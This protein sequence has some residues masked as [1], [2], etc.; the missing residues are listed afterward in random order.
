MRE[1]ARFDQRI[2]SRDAIRGIDA[3][4]FDGDSTDG[5]EPVKDRSCPKEVVLPTIAS[6]V[7]ERR[8]LTG[9]GLQT[10]DIWPLA[11]VAPGAALREVP[12]FG[13]PAVLTGDDVIEGEGKL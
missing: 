12:G 2:A 1:E 5:S 13:Q 7:E 10:R 6:R 11:G 8:E 4:D 3:Q 9:I